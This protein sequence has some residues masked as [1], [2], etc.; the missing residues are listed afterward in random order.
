M[1]IPV[2]PTTLLTVSEH[3]GLSNLHGSGPWVGLST[4]TSMHFRTQPALKQAQEHSKQMKNGQDIPKMP[5][6]AY[7][8]YF[9][10]ILDVLGL[11]LSRKTCRLWVGLGVLECDLRYSLLT[12]ILCVCNLICKQ[13]HLS[14]SSHLL[15]HHMSALFISA[16]FVYIITVGL[17]I[18]PFPGLLQLHLSAASL[19]WSNLL[20]CILLYALS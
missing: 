8:S 20:S 3:H 4:G 19:V 14:V 1:Q 16:N 2:F 13:H 11:I 7:L 17:F 18:I 5:I 15:Q 10:S 12:S 6:L 9:W